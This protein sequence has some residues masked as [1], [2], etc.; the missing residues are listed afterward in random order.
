MER[1]G[2]NTSTKSL[3]LLALLIADFYNKIGKKA[4]YAVQR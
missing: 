2:M 4:T 1:V 3:Q